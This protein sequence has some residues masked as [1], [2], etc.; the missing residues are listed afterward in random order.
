M[1]QLRLRSKASINRHD[2][3]GERVTALRAAVQ[4]L[5]D[6]KLDEA[7]RAFAAIL[8]RW[9]G[10][11][12]ALHF[13][14]ILRHTQGRSDDGIALIRR[15]ISA[16]PAQ[17][18]PWNNLGNVLVECQRLDEALQAYEAST[19]T[20]KDRPESAD[21]WNNIGTLRRKRHEWAAAE[22]AC[23]RAVELR[24]DFGDAWYNLS[25]ALIGQERI[26]EGLV[27]NSKA[28]TLWPRH[29]QGR[30]QVIRALLLLGER[31]KAAELY[32]EWLAE[33]P[34]NPVV[35]HQLVACLGHTAPARASDAYVETVFD[36]FA[37]SFDA[38]LESL[39][40][41]APQHVADQLE[42]LLPAPAA[43]FD[44][45]D[46]GCGTGLVGALIKPWA[47][48]LAGCDLSVGMLRKA[49]VRNVYD[50]LHKAEL[51]FYLRTQPAA[52]DVIVSADTLCYVGDLAAVCAAAH[53]ALQSAGWFVFT[54]EALTGSSLPHQL[55]AT[56]R[57]AHA[58]VHVRNAL[59]A[60]GFAQVRLQ[61]VRLRSEAGEPVMGWLVSAQRLEEPA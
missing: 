13:Q 30:D 9:P 49:R 56:G 15:A 38:K 51:V 44:I 47:R 59:E 27:A 11:A 25:L 37:R 39:D 5:R 18:G 28:I 33:E 26:R 19:G 4:L 46:V 52:F 21:A 12:D 16:M 24:P 20:A 29:L 32:R 2:G 50:V 10:D 6:E 34:D 40:Y 43:Q 55:R 1:A 7:D 60:A 22:Q 58:E 61:E 45:A 36:S 3:A 53:L 17:A 8:Q 23:R 54:V 35:E 14:G 42:R 48:R 41:R 57:Y 31:D